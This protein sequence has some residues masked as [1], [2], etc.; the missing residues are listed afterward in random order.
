MQLCG[1]I[2]N[3]AIMKNRV[4]HRIY[5]FLLFLSFF[6]LT[7]MSCGQSYEEKRRLS[8]AELMEQ[9]K[10]DSLALKL[11][12]LP[13]LDALPIYLAKEY[14]LFDTLG[15]DVRL[16]VRNA[17]MDC[18][19]TLVGGHVEGMVTD[20]VRAERIVRRGTP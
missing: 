10:A 15:L 17:Q 14:H 8:R 9:K 19:T 7:I 3:F 5:A 13:T 18:D 1:I 6:F 12:V 20:L 2:I 16:S 4:D 11:A